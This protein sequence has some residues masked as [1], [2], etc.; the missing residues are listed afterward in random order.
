MYILCDTFI[1]ESVASISSFYSD[2]IPSPR[3]GTGELPLIFFNWFKKLHFRDEFSNK[4]DNPNSIT[5][6]S[7]IEIISSS[8]SRSR[9]YILY[10]STEQ[11]ICL[12]TANQ[13]NH[14]KFKK[15]IDKTPT[16]GTILSN[17]FF[18]FHKKGTLRVY[19][20]R[21]INPCVP[22]HSRLNSGFRNFFF[23]SHT[24]WIRKLLFSMF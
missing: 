8:S 9:F 15:Q 14:E 2:E 10:H 18:F 24:A 7:K 4:N 23:F 3:P 5:F 16:P 13:Y 17:F 6:L 19:V 21:N 11:R 22:Q 1:I 12:A 20:F